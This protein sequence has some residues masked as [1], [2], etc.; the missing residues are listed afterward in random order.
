[1]DNQQERLNDLAWLT[2]AWEADG[3]FQLNKN[4]LRRQ[5]SHQLAPSAGF[6]NTDLEFITEV[7]RILKESGIAYHQVTR[8]QTGLGSKVIS[9]IRV[10]GIKRVHRFLTMLIP[11]MKSEK[12]YEAKLILEF[13]QLRLERPSKNYPYMKEEWGIYERFI[14][15]KSL[16]AKGSLESSTTNTLDSPCDKDRV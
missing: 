5:K 2:G 3:S 16:R 14:D 4:N 13:C 10:I 1:M 15:H 9:Q 7:I 8:V 6:T 11:Y 12:R